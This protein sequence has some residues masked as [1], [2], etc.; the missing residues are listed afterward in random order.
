MG[1]ALLAASSVR[2]GPAALADAADDMIEYAKEV[3]PDPALVGAY[4]E[5]YARFKGDLR[6]I[7]GVHA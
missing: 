7:Y 5:I 3:D 4:E 2:G 6:I 1:S